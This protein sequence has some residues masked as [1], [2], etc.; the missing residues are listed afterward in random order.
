[1][2]AN[3]SETFE[4][5]I[6][7]ASRAL[8]TPA[9]SD[10]RFSSLASIAAHREDFVHACHDT[11]KRWHEKAVQEILIFD[12]FARAEQRRPIGAS[13]KE[14]GDYY[15]AVWCRVNDAIVWSVFGTRRDIIKRLCPG[16]HGFRGAHEGGAS[17]GF[18]RATNPTQTEA[19]RGTSLDRCVFTAT[20]GSVAGIYLGP[21]RCRA[22]HDGGDPSGPETQCRYRCG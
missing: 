1:M 6:E 9:G 18:K 11:W 14:Y 21:P 7:A 16:R 3:F 12:A 22:H 15:R 20:A 19:V 10:D 4:E 17:A 2:P 5:T 8:Q 13:A